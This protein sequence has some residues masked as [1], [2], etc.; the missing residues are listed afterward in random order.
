[1]FRPAGGGDDLQ[2][3]YFGVM[4]KSS[5]GKPICI[6]CWKA[7]IDTYEFVAVPINNL[8]YDSSIDYF[9]PD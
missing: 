8:Q 5:P 7:D 9:P 2:R 4:D 6:K 1:M 3:S